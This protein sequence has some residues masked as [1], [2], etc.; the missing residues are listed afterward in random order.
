MA[1]RKSALI[2][3]NS[4]YEDPILRQLIAPAHDAEA[5]AQVLSDPA[6][7]G[8]EVQTVLNEPHYNV[9]REI[10]ALFA[11]RNRGDLLLLYFSCHGVTDEDGLL[12]YAACNTNRKWL[13]STAVAAN[14]VN[15][16]MNRCRSRRQ[17]LLL[18]CCHS[19]AFARTK[20]AHTVNTGQH[21]G[22]RTPEEGRGRFVLT[23][24]DA[25]QYSFEGDAV[26]GQAVY[27]VFTQALVQGLRTGEADLDG[28]GLITL[29]EL[30]EYVYRRVTDQTPNQ[31]PRKW[32]YEVDL[33]IAIA[34]N[35]RAVEKARLG[36][37]ERERPAA[38]EKARLEQA[39]GEREAATARPAA[40]IVL[41]DMILNWLRNMILNIL[42]WLTLVPVVICLLCLPQ[43]LW[44]VS[45]SWPLAHPGGGEWYRH[46]MLTSLCF[47]AVASAFAVLSMARARQKSLIKESG[48]QGTT[49]LEF[50]AFGVPCL[51]ASWLL[52]ETWLRG[53]LH[54]GHVSYAYLLRWQFRF[55]VILPFFM[56]LMRL[57]LLFQSD[58]KSEPTPFHKHDGSGR[59]AW[60]R[61]LGSLAAPLLAAELAAGLLALCLLFLHRVLFAPGYDPE[62]ASQGVQVLSVPLVIVLFL[63]SAFFVS[64]LLRNIEQEEEREWW[65]RAGGML[66]RCLFFW[67]SLNGVAFFANDVLRFIHVTPFTALGVGISSEYLG[68]MLG[69]SGA[70]SNDLKRVRVEPLSKP[71]R[72]LSKRDGLATVASA[73]ALL[74]ITFAMAFFTSWLRVVA[75]PLSA[76]VLD[77]L[78]SHSGSVPH[79]LSSTIGAWNW[80]TLQVR[81]TMDLK[82]EL[83][84]TLIVFV[85]AG[86]AAAPAVFGNLFI[87]VNTSSPYGVYPIRLTRKEAQR[88]RA[89][90]SSPL[91]L[92]LSS[93]S[94]KIA[95]ALCVILV[96]AFVF[97]YNSAS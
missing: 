95:C 17:V 82:T 54:G 63:A 65:V 14:F 31:S 3:A 91:I 13:R 11:D 92:S 44:I 81:P 19:G 84:S 12:Y 74:C 22:G 89:A 94:M 20:A 33:G 77:F 61:L 28:D 2:I 41:R 59:L 97:W 9:Q 10:E 45:Y 55:A 8:F 78:R 66:F 37:E 64:G 53:A 96:V 88:K 34:R 80:Q 56:S 16:S 36:E 7:S 15:D 23:A 72:F 29:D 39:E 43:F 5:L 18:D 93:T 57:R 42:N 49:S 83:V 90:K 35:P 62:F 87:S 50:W 67:I 4:Q 70:T 21:F 60:H 26:E 47:M 69:S 32:A 30:Y 1:E 25:Y 38:A 24:S 75:A 52:G 27:S 58:G 86:T 68:R 40:A 71:R 73:I 79:F 76:V 48:K 51:L 85:F 6:I 46:V